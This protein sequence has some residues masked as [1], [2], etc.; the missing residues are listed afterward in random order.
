[1]A[2][3]TNESVI[4]PTATA[5]IAVRGSFDPNAPLTIAPARGESTV[6]RSRI[7]RVE[8]PTSMPQKIAEIG[9]SGVLESVIGDR[10]REPERRLGGRDGDHDEGENLSIMARRVCAVEADEQEVHGV[11]HQLD[12]HQLDE[13]VPPNE[14]TD[15]ANPE[16]K[17]AENDVGAD[18]DIHL[19]LLFFPAL[20]SRFA[21]KLDRRLLPR[22]AEYT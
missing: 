17:R 20:R 19:A 6:R 21:R 11:Q 10:E 8:S 7:E 5:E 2:A 12:A 4:D 18:L 16:E 14:E 22:D 1:M 15:R 3:K 13:E 9:L